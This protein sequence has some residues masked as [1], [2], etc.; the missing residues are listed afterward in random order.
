MNV[1]KSLLIFRVIMAR[2]RMNVAQVLE[3]VL[4]SSDDELFD[5]DDSDRDAELTDRESGAG[6]DV[7]ICTE[8]N[9]EMDNELKLNQYVSSLIRLESVNVQD[10]DERASN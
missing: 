7:T 9:V 2:K 3:A 6:D 1:H 4:H 8:I 10:K 5:D